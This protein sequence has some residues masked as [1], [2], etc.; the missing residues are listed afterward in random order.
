MDV[1]R[2]GRRL[3]PWSKVGLLVFAGLTSNGCGAEGPG[4]P[5]ATTVSW[6][7]DVSSRSDTMF[8]VR[9]FLN[10]ESIYLEPAAAR[11]VHVV[12]LVRPLSAGGQRIEMEILSADRSPSIYVASCTAAVGGDGGSSRAVHADGIPWTLGIGERLFLTITL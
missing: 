11:T 8:G 10:G 5:D 3:A 7:I 9:I 1:G 2:A 4:G 6:R 12:H